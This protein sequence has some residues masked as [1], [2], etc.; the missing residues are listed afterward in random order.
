MARI[1]CAWLSLVVAATPLLLPANP[2][3]AQS[4][5]PVPTT[6][7]TPAAASDGLQLKVRRLPDAVELVLE[8]AG[9][10]ASLTQQPLADRWQGDLRTDRPRAL[11]VGPQSLALPA[12]GFERISFDGRGDTFRL[13]VTPVAGRP[14]ASPVISSDGRD[15]VV[16]FA[17][18]SNVL[19]QTA[20]YNMRQ[21]IPVPTESFVPPL[22]PRAVAPPVGDMAVGTMTIQNRGFLNISGPPV[23]LTTR[24]AN[25]RD[26][27]MVLAQMGG[28]GFAYSDLQPRKIKQGT[29]LFDQR[30]GLEARSPDSQNNEGGSVILPK[31]TVFFK[32]ESFSRAFNFVLASSG[33]Q[34]RLEGRTILVG[35]AVLQQSLGSQVSKVYRLNQASADSAADYLANLGALVTKTFQEK[36]TTT[37]GVPLAGASTSNPQTTRTT[38][39]TKVLQYGGERGPLL[40]LQAT[41]DTRLG[42][43][44]VVGESTLV[45]FAQEYLRQLDLRQRQVALSVKILDVNLSNDTELDN[46]FAFRF[47]NNFI[48]NDSG[49]LLGAFGRNLP[50]NEATFNRQSSGPLESIQQSSSAD[51]STSLVINRSRGLDLTRSQLRNINNELQSATGFRL[52]EIDRRLVVSPIDSQS[53]SLTNSTQRSIERIISRNIGRS[54]STTRNSSSASS[55]SVSG[56][57]RPNPG[58]LYPDNTF[59]DFVRAQIESSNTKILANPTLILQE[60]NEPYGQAGSDSTRVSS[61]GKVGRSR[62]NEAYVRVGTQFVTAYKIRQDVN[63]NNFCEPEFSNAGLT[64]G[65]KVDKIDDNGFVTFGLSP[66]ISAPVGAQRVGNCG[67][68][69]LINDRLLDTGK[70]RV[71]DGQT[72]ILTGVISE[73]DRSVVSKWPILGDIPLIGQFFRRSGSQRTKNELVIMVTPRIINDDQGGSFGYG[74]QPSTEDGRRMLYGTSDR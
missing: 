5:R 10:G 22:R 4:R 14:L 46:S 32:N 48:V 33:L 71:R 50:P 21:P 7:S 41:T 64:F 36:I 63:G 1:G 72:L 59:F 57:L 73:T 28:Y 53:N 20:R 42:T 45:S 74:F 31:V 35:A 12:E 26:I 70:L 30:P 65:A 38:E 54:I 11:K 2:G 19:G 24:G 8:Q 52:T 13:T 55:S 60:G 68:I 18:Q 40:G 62:S 44:T 66:E 43:I 25:P 51:S 15:L 69:T 3:L 39:E 29:D 17:A 67:D 47:G 34:A 37:E 49:Q 56:S 58:S 27:L 16:S 9:L 23:T 6:P 61:D